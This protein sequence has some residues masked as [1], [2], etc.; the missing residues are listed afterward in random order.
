MPSPATDPA[1]AHLWPYA[2]CY[3]A[4]LMALAGTD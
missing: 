1:T 2:V 4:G 3:V